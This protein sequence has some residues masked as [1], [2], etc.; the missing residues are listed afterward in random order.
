M[1]PCIPVL[2]QHTVF[3]KRVIYKFTLVWY[4]A[5]QDTMHRPMSHLAH[6]YTVPFLWLREEHGW[7]C[8]WVDD[9]AGNCLLWQ[10]SSRNTFFAAALGLPT[11]LGWGWSWLFPASWIRFL[12]PGA[13]NLSGYSEPHMM[14]TVPSCW[15][16]LTTTMVCLIYFPLYD[17]HIFRN[18]MPLRY[19]CLLLWQQNRSKSTM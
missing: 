4:F 5:K 11:N 7:Q 18:L 14:V 8:S 15:M 9:F 17:W 19:E 1:A 16:L 6:L 13:L 3:T 2:S 12:T 10:L